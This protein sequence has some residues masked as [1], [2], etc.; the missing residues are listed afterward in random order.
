MYFVV[1][2]HKNVDLI[3]SV[4]I[5]FVKKFD[6]YVN[7]G[8]MIKNLILAPLN[9]LVILAPLPDMIGIRSLIHLGNL[10]LLSFV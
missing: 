6:F 3:T 9:A 4:C 1:I 8:I 7:G 2:L 5:C 10:V